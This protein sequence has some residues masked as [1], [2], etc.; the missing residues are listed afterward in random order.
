MTREYKQGTIKQWNLSMYDQTKNRE[1]ENGV[2]NP[3]V[4]VQNLV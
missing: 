3:T 4:K 1:E 2:Q